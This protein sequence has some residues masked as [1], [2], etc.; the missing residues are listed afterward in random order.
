MDMTS[1]NKPHYRFPILKNNE[2][3]E[4]LTDAGIE[5][6]SNELTE[7]NRHKEKIKAIYNELESILFS[8]NDVHV[9][10]ARRRSTH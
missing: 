4:C 1:S 8:G 6:T 5:V 3:I 10:S 2:I 7:P 9:M